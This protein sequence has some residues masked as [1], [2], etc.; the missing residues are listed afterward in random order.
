MDD[1]TR[2][3]RAGEFKRLSPAPDQPEYKPS[4]QF[5]GAGGGNT[6][7][8]GIEPEELEAI[9][10]ILTGGHVSIKVLIYERLIA[11]GCEMENHESDLYVVVTPESTA[12]LEFYEFRENVTTF[13]SQIDNKPWYDVPF[14]YKSFWDNKAEELKT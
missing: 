7:V 4:V 6:N 3:Y 13:I 2:A 9:K 8:M 1:Q 11:A 14:F 5:H 12:I 10:A